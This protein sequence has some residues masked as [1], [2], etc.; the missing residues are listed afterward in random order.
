MYTNT[1]SLTE[2]G[3][4]IHC[5]VFLVNILSQPYSQQIKFVLNI[6]QLDKTTVFTSSVNNEASKVFSDNDAKMFSV[7]SIETQVSIKLSRELYNLSIY[8][9]L[10]REISGYL[11]THYS[12]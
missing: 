12:Y 1:F 3:F 6:F 5:F 2:T 8:F 9:G 10:V 4:F 7:T 11:V